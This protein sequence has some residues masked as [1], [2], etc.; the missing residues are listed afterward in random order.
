MNAMAGGRHLCCDIK[1]HQL[2]DSG[3]YHSPE[4]L[5]DIY[6]NSYVYEEYYGG[7]DRRIVL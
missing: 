2:R 1:R 7:T 6:E 3:G 5:A 4:I